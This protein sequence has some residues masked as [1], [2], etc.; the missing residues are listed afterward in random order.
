MA[1]EQQTDEVAGAAHQHRDE[2]WETK[3]ADVRD[4]EARHRL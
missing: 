2:E 1:L 4:P 3:I